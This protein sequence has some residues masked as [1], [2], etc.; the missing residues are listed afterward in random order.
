MSVCKYST[1][2]ASVVAVEPITGVAETVERVL[3]VHTDVLTAA[4]VSGTL[5]HRTNICR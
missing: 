3:G 5:V 2:A 1:I 4:V